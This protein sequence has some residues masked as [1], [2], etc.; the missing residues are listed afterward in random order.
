MRIRAA[1]LPI[2]L[3]FAFGLIGIAKGQSL[4]PS[5]TIRIDSGSF[6]F[7]LGFNLVE[8]TVNFQDSLYRVRFYGMAQS[9]DVYHGSGQVYGLQE[10]GKIVG[11]YEPAADG[12]AFVNEAGVEI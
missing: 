10:I 6:L 3:A 9:S 8:A 12:R 4:E 11:R 1:I 5:A 2:A 7:A